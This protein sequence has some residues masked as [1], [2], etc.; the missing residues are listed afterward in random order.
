MIPARR[1]RRLNGLGCRVRGSHPVSSSYK[2][3]IYLRTEREVSP[4]PVLYN[5]VNRLGAWNVRG[6]NDTTKRE[7]VSDVFREGKLKLLALFET[8]LKGSREISWYGVNG[9]I[10]GVEKLERVR[11]GMA[12]LL[13]DVWHCAVVDF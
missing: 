7:E 6:I 1:R 10:S 11:E 8:K 5:Y 9:V 2:R 13:N 12:I 4:T 3:I